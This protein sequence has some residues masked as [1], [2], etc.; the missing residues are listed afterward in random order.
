VPVRAGS[1]LLLFFVV[2]ISVFTGAP[3]QVL[4]S[5]NTNA[6]RKQRAQE[7][8]TLARDAAGGEKVLRGIK[9]ISGSARLRSFTKYVFVK[10][11]TQVEER[12]KILKGK[13]KIEFLF[14]DKSRS[15]ISSPTL[16]GFQQK[17]S[18]VT[19]GDRAWRDPPLI[20]YSL[21]R[22]RQVIDV[23]DYEMSLAYQAQGARQNLSIYS[24]GWL[25]QA[26]PNITLEYRYEGLLTIDGTVVDAI[27]VSGPNNFGAYFL[28]DRTTHLSSGFI[29]NFTATLVDPVLTDV[30][31]FDNR[32]RAKPILARAMQEIASRSR[33]RRR[34]SVLIRFLDHRRNGDL[35]LPHRLTTSIDDRPYEELI[36]S[37]FY[38]NGYLNPKNFIP[39]P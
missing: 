5:S 8:L 15:V 31:P 10:S 1:I 22:G 37:K 35:L 26:P 21:R 28:L 4:D 27:E 17:Y 38:V 2:G 3:E 14:P 13:V 29:I 11:P 20:P 9:S 39:P 25:L 32:N 33:P 19:S 34:Y 24:L 30:F 12:E 6:A 18:L 23:R 7:L 36:F 16:F